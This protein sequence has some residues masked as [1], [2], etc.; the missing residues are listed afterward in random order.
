MS[1]NE[2]L[3][4]LCTRMTSEGKEWLTE[5]M[6][7]S[8][9]RS[10]G[11]AIDKLIIQT[12]S[13]NQN[14]LLGEILSEEIAT[15]VIAELKEPIDILRR[16]T[17]YSDRQTKVLTEVLNH[18]VNTLQ[19]DRMKNEVVTTN[20]AKTNVMM[21]AEERVKEQLDHFAQQAATKKAQRQLENVKANE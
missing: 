8:Q 2:K 13:Q 6:K 14:Q 19:L 3:E 17:G 4:R 10:L 11:E 1:D 9:S 20:L 5:Y 18:M 21:V 12:K 16:R 15:R 7:N